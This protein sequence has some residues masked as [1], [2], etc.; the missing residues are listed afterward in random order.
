MK[1]IVLSAFLIIILSVTQTVS[2]Q[3]RDI[4]VHDPVMI[5]H[6]GMYYIF[7]TDFGLKMWS[8][9]DLDNWTDEGAIFPEAP[10]WTFDV[11]PDFKNH[12]WAPDITYHNGKFYLFY[13]VSAFGRNTSAIAVATNTTLD[14]DSPDYKWV[15]HGPVIRS[16]PG[17]DM[18]N[19]IDPNLAFDDEG[20]PWLTFGS[21]WMGIKIVRL[22][23]SLTKVYEPQTWRTI[24]ARH[25]DWKVDE[26]DAGDA[27]NPELNYAELYSEDQLEANQ[28]M[29]NGAIEAPFIFKKNGYYY[30]LFSWDRCCKGLESSYK[31]VVGR[32]KNVMGPYVDKAGNK[33]IHGGG[34]VIASET[35]R[36]AAVGHPA[37][38]T[39]DGVD[40]LVAHAYDKND[41]GKPKL[42]LA[43]I[44]WDENGWPSVELN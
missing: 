37:A 5:E 9:P 31:T 10:E 22:D 7:N 26:R 23:D 16:V 17:R 1:K 18:W 42:I 33:L 25:R 3:Y 35:D 36:W 41:D 21:F 32:A 30:L 44:T 19:A 14:T 15:D 6:D 24:A 39:F 40:F 8:S 12:M 29:Q 4:I 38:Y 20:H 34:T 11:N 28:T 27:A 2:A 43:E 13:S